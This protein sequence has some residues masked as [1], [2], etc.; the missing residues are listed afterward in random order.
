MT[1][2]RY[3]K[4]AGAF[5]TWLARHS[6]NQNFLIVGFYKI[7]SG[8]PSMTWPESVDEALC[9]GWIDGVRTRIDEQAYK[10]RFTPRKV[11]SIWSSVNIAKVEALIAQGRMQPAGLA[12]Y[13]LR[14]EAKSSIYA[15][16]QPAKLELPPLAL[17]SFKKHKAAWHYFT[18]ATPPGYQKQMTHRINS[19]KR[20]D[21]R[22]RR[23]T[24]LI[25]ACVR[26]ERLS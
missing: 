19:A 18:T 26:H 8:Q 17:Q 22:E 21:T 24:L 16:E 11:T 23:L 9:H 20:E 13:A 6:S 2:P 1:T 12:A 10:I 15:Y 14:S 5:G 3:F 25:E 4:T 7:G